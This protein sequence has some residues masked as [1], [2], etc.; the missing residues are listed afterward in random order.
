V[1]EAADAGPDDV[2]VTFAGV[3]TLYIT[4][5]TTNLM[6]DGFFS[7]PGVLD[8]MFSQ[9]EPD[10]AAIDAALA[11][12]GVSELDAIF[13]VHA[14]YD[15]ALDTP[16]VARKTGA[17]MLGG[18][19]AAMIARGVDLPEDQIVTVVA[20]EAYTFGAFDIRFIESAHAP[21]PTQS[22]MLPEIDEPL[23]PPADAF[24]Y[25]TGHAW[26]ILI[27]HRDADGVRKQMLVQGSAGFVENNL[28]G[29]QVD[30]VFL[31]SGGLGSQKADR[32]D[33]YW[34]EMVALPDAKKVYPTHW[35]D[36]FL[37]LDEPLLPT[38]GPMNDFAGGMDYMIARAKAEGRELKMMRAF[39]TVL[40]FQD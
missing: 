2:R 3:S 16:V 5:G 25:P 18:E 17:V 1:D 8:V 33:G 35:D 13:P 23:V 14:H 24:A 4:D 26:A 20:G 10:D 27:G 7:R 19:S 29:E 30:A 28:Q 22:A 39:A 11:K 21:V 38:G 36:F 37:P 32:R 6:V 31:G 34:N 12:L 40:P 9:I 15:H